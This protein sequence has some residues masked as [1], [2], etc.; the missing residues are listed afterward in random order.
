MKTAP[1]RP[2]PGRLGDATRLK[3]GSA[4]HIIRRMGATT[5]PFVTPRPAENACKICG[6]RR[7][8]VFAHTAT[9]AD[10]GVLLNY[11]YAPVREDHFL[12]SRPLT[13]EEHEKE[14]EH[15]TRWYVMSGERNHH[16]FTRMVQFALTEE[17]RRGNLIVL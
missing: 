4:S 13:Q 6:S 1:R 2:R 14:Q 17:D 16:N 3:N 10:C 15:W 12:A 11:P 9:C 7:L 8:K 5:L